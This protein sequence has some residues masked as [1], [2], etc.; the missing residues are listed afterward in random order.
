MIVIRDHFVAPYNI[1]STPENKQTNKQTNIISEFTAI[2]A[3][4]ESIQ[5]SKQNYSTQFEIIYKNGVFF[6]K[7][8]NLK[9]FP[10]FHNIHRFLVRF[11]WIVRVL[12]YR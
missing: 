5:R 8:G 11:P 3:L 10:P 9:S 6:C 2:I 12:H 1:Q 4:F 7:I